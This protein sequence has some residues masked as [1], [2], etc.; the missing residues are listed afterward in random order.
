MRNDIVPPKRPN[1]PVPPRRPLAISQDS[2]PPQSNSS[3]EVDSP[4]AETPVSESKLSRLLQHQ[5]LL[6]I[7]GA[8]GALLVVMAIAL[9]VWYNKELAAVTPGKDE[10]VKVV[11]APG[12]STIDI[13]STLKQND[14]VRSQA[15]FALYVRVTA[16]AAHLQSGTYRLSKSEDVP[17]IVKHLTSGH[18]DTF[19]MTFLPGATVAENRQVLLKAGYSQAQVDAALNKPYDGPLFEGKPAGTDLEGYIYGETYQF[20]ADV[21]PEQILRR[22]FEQ[23]E[24][25]V[26]KENLVQRYKDHGFNLY[27]G[28]TLASIIQREVAAPSDS[29]QVAQVFELRLKKNMA[30]G[31]DVTYQYI[32][33]K[34]GQPRSVNIDSPYNTRKYPGL[35]PGPISTP[36][37]AALKAVGNPAPGDYL[38]F[39]SGDDD[40]TYFARTN[41][42]HEKNIQQH[43][44]KKCQIT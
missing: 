36:G 3:P 15:A 4:K 23:F 16:K 21:N 38:F 34:T 24:Q 5:R 27:Q 32:A 1:T 13:A 39:I 14:L 25:V 11:I 2:S 30:L 26:Q 37:L 6:V 22:T 44:Q 35:P 33:D 18:T 41:E 31:S 28:I 20:S 9:T 40:K 17:A 8:I 42:E 7:I 12:S 29:A 10:K 43:C 19:S